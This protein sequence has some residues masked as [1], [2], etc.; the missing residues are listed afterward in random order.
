[1]SEQNKLSRKDDLQTV[2]GSDG[3]GGYHS[4][5]FEETQA[6]VDFIN[7]QLQSDEE[8]KDKVPIQ[9]ANDLFEVIKDGVLLCKLVNKAA[10]GTI[11]E[12]VIN[13][14]PEGKKL[15]PWQVSENHQLMINSAKAIGCNVVNCGPNDLSEGTAHIVMGL[16]WQVIKVALLQDIN[17]K[18]CPELVRLLEEGETLEDLLKLPAEQLLIRWVNF[19]LKAAESKR[20]IANFSGD[21]KDSEV[22]TILLNQISPNKECSLTP[23]QEEDVSKRAELVL[24]EADKI[25]CREFVTA[26]DIT[27]GN[28]KLNLAFVANLFNKYPALEEINEEDY[29]F[30]D[31]LDLDGA[32][33]REERQFRFWI[34]S[35]GIPDIEENYALQNLFEDLHDGI[36]LLH[37]LDHIEPGTVNWKNVR[38]GAKNKFQQVANCNHY[39]ECAKKVGFSTVNVGGTDIFDRQKKLILGQTWQL[40]KLASLKLLQKVGGGK[41]IEDKDVLAWANN[42]VGSNIKSFKDPSLGDGKWLCNLCAAVSPRSVNKELITEGDNEEEK[43]QN[44]KYAISVARKIGAVVFLLWEDVVEVNPKQLLLFAVA[45]MTIDLQSNK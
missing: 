14:A 40:M 19:H 20:R 31:V 24:I 4:Y 32:G 1:M 28:S 18:A 34:Q 5:T 23:L 13:K 39:V 41:K 35:L 27:N 2:S 6:F 3:S 25:D 12:R 7:G 37:V 8:V 21:I 10:E 38:K 42:K 30:A 26:R 17:L 15:N 11:D 43:E 9:N 45:L 29:D 36:V 16:V 44:A 22:Y 33:S